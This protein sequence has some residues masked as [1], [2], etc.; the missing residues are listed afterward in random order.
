MSLHEN[1]NYNGVTVV[2]LTTSKNLVVKSKKA[3][4]KLHVERFNLKKLNELEVRK[5]YQIKISKRFAASK[6]LNY[7]KG[8]KQG[9]RLKSQKGLQLQRT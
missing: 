8:K 2:N 6:N 9:F 4:E 7:S 5:Q 1:S 3:A